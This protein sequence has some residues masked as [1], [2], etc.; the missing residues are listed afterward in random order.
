MPVLPGG[1]GAGG[2]GILPGGSRHNRAW[3]APSEDA[4][5]L[6]LGTQPE[7]ARAAV[8]EPAEAGVTAAVIGEVRSG[9][10]R[11]RLRYGGDPRERRPAAVRSP[12]ASPRG[13]GHGRGATLARIVVGCAR[14]GGSRPRVGDPRGRRATVA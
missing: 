11:I 13:T 9:Y 2:I 5:G 14:A 3:V 8:A 7:R 6:L 4:G 12:R 10:G 1:P